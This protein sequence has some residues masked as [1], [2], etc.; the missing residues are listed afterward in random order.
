MI[1]IANQYAVKIDYQK[2]GKLLETMILFSPDIKIIKNI[3]IKYE[4]TGFSKEIENIIEND[5]T[6]ISYI[7][8]NY[9]K[10]EIFAFRSITSHYELFYYEQKILGKG[11]EVE[12]DIIITDHIIN[13]LSYLPVSKRSLCIEGICDVFLYQHSYGKETYIKNIYRLGYGELLSYQ[14]NKISVQIVQTLELGKYDLK[15][16][17][18]ADVLENS[19]REA[20]QKM[21]KKES[22]NTLSGG[23]DSTLTHII[24]GNPHSISGSYEYPKFL[25]EKE[26]AQEAARLLHANHVVYD[27]SM[28]DYMNYMIK[29]VKHY[30]LSVYNMTAQIIH[31][32]LAECVE[33]EHMFVSELAGAVYGLELRTPYTKEQAEKYSFFDNYNYANV[34]SSIARWED[35]QK[36]SNIFGKTMIDKQLTKRND[37][38]LNRLKGFDTY[39]KSSDNYL[40]LGHLMYWF[41]NNGVSVLEQTEM[42]FKKTI[43][44]L[45][46]ARKVVE[47]FLSL[48]LHERYKNEQYGEKPYAKQ[49][50][51]K[52]LPTYDVKKKKLGGSLPRTYM[53]TE[54]PM[55]GYFRKHKIPD[56]VDKSLYDIILAPTWETSWCVKYLIM[57]S[58]WYENVMCCEVEKIPSKFQI[59]LE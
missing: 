53:V 17:Q 37:Y 52:L 57:Y 3:R 35:V 14:E 39:D 55:A 22:I 9:L 33:Q 41:T 43:S 10:H 54:G 59:N 30:G 32:V 46:S 19:L 58:V 2:D 34:N 18:G 50:L 36:I 8:I 21:Q 47:E 12:R 4:N 38:V 29:T 31:H 1:D 28:K 5:Q 27:I 15:K 26:Y 44:A 42:V 49:L 23:I 48:E 6:E 40:Q 45:F 24:M 16:E 51:E 11:Y 25:C 13:M 7:Q 56:F 20:C